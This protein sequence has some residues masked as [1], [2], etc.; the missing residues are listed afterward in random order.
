MTKRKE[1]EAA[2]AKAE[3]ALADAVINAT[4]VDADRVEAN[5]NLDKTRAYCRQV[6]AAL[7]ELNRS[8]SRARSGEW[9]D[10]LIK[11]FGEVSKR[12]ATASSPS[13]QASEHVVRGENKRSKDESRQRKPIHWLN[14]GFSAQEPSRRDALARSPL[15]RQT[16][17][18]QP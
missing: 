17:A 15:L 12:G 6:R 11:Q 4:K 9:I 2:L 13:R 3:A 1:L 18:C 16:S 7:V 10:T 5:A 14:I 8:E